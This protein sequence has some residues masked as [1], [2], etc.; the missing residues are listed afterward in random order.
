MKYRTMLS[1][2]LLGTLLAAPGWGQQPKYN[3]YAQ[4]QKNP[5]VLPD[6]TINWPPFFKSAAT[7]ARF[8]MY[9]KMGSCKGTNPRINNMLKDNKV[10]VNELSVVS[11][12][13]RAAQVSAAGV[14][15]KETSGITDTLFVHPMGVSRISVTGKIPES[16]VVAGMTLRFVGQVDERGNGT[17]PIRSIEVITP[18]DKVKPPK[19]FGGQSQTIIG[20]VL[21]RE[22]NRLQMVVNSAGIKRL[23]VMVDANTQVEVNG[24]SLDLLWPGDEISVKGHLY[25]G[26]GTSTGR[27]IF[28][29]DLIV[30]KAKAAPAAT[31]PRAEQTAAK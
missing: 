17:E 1:L 15:M 28:A 5:P 25:L 4:F 29:D 7:E 13:G 14:Q 2:A 24:S 22:G 19:V 9:F 27:A 10:E 3:P 30:T 23:N 18:T 8:Q 11:L 21:K 31:E 16:T 20:T 6:G 26:E 12:S